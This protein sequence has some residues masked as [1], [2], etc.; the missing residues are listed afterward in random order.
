[1]KTL[2]TFIAVIALTATAYGQVTV[3]V[4]DNGDGT[5]TVTITPVG[6]PA[7]VGIGLT[8]DAGAGSTSEP[9]VGVAFPSGAFFD[10]AIDCYHD[11][12]SAADDVDFSDDGCHPGAITNAAGMPTLPT[13]GSENPAHSIAISVGELNALDAD[14]LGGGPIDIA[15]IDLGGAGDVCISDNG[16]RGGV[17]AVD[18]SSQAITNNGACFPITSGGCACPGDATTVDITPFDGLDGG[19]TRVDIYDLQGMANYVLP[20][21][22]S[23]DQPATPDTLCWDITTT[24]I[25]P[26]DGLDG[27]NGR[28]D[29]YDLQ[30]MA[31]YLLPTSPAFD[32]PCIP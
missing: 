2:V 7:S 23:F 21:S 3:G 6:G 5:G 25:T 10:V 14:S 29:I 30:A 26:F 9:I 16:I 13:D 24:D 11:V 19:N 15:V 31:N 1:M 32:Q 17:V 27:P 28:V 22:P 20:T 12:P 8:V 18:G 4:T